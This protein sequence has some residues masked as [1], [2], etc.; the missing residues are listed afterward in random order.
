MPTKAAVREMLP[1]NRVTWASRYS[2]SNTSRASQ[3]QRHDLAAL[4]PFDD[5]RG[6]RGD[7]VRQHVGADR[8]LWVA[9]RHDQ[10]PVDDV[11]EL[12]HVAGPGIGLQR[13]QR[14]LAELARRH[15][16]R[17][18][19]ARH[20]MPRQE[21]DVLAPVAQRR[22]FDRHDAEAVE[23]ILAE[24]PRRNLARQLAVRRSHHPDI[25]LDPVG[26]ANPLECL[27]LQHPHNLALGLDR[28]VGDFVEEQRAAMSA[29]ERADLAAVDAVLA[30][31]ELGLEP[32][33]VHRRA[34]DRDKRPLCPPRARMEKPPDDLF[35][36]AGQARNQ[37]AAAGRRDAVDLLAKLVCRVRRTDKIKVAARAQ[38]Q[39]L[40][41]APER[42][43]FDRPRD[44]QQQP[45]GLERLF[46]KIVGADPDRLD[47]GL[48]RAVAADH[49]H[50]HRRDVGAELAQDLDAVELAALE[51]DVEDDQGRLAHLDR[52]G[53][54]I[55][56]GGLAGVVAL[57]L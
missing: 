35:A 12:A 56:V 32:I 52:R 2:R 31:E 9:G 1:P 17:L 28:H 54:L 48:D 42:R 37:H 34:V 7:L 15:S 16:G 50:R 55:A 49:H 6:D 53:H 14:I 33:G 24:P 39:L 25:D 45:V 51:P 10:Q 8:L 44:Q 41:L 43:A 22:H 46:D 36:G 19:R 23:Q 30:A 57:V 13:G 27:L 18:G 5:G 38:L 40:V 20:E 4:V 47:R 26:P 29:L 21:R 3:R 11:P